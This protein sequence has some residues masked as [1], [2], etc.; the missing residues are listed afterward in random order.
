MSKYQL[1]KKDG[2]SVIGK[3]GSSQEGAGFVERQW[4]EAENHLKEILPVVRYRSGDPIFWGLMSDFSHSLQ[5]WEKDFTEGLYLAGF[6]LLDPK[7]IPPEGWAKWDVPAMNYLVI[8][9]GDSYP[10]SFKEGL[11]LLTS[12]GYV[13]SAAV[14]DHAER[15]KTYLYYPIESLS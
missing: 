13:L 2:F 10:D 14:F 5:P 1:V 12:L 3:E 4:N 11:A 15:G 7:L 9:V 8:E 6:E